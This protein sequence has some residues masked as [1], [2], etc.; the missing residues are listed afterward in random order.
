MTVSILTEI[1]EA[2]HDRLR[3][4]LAATDLDEDEAI[5]AANRA[6]AHDSREERRC[7]PLI[8]SPLYL[9]EIARYPVLTPDEERSLLLALAKGD[10]RAK[11]KLIKHNLRLVVSV[12]K[13]HH[14]YAGTL[15]LIDLIQ[16]GAF[17][18]KTA[19]ERFDLKY[20]KLS[21]YAVQWIRQKITR[22]IQNNGR[23]VRLPV[24]C[25][26]DIRVISKAASEL[27]RQFKR[28]ATFA[29]IAAAID[30]PPAWVTGRLES[31]RPI[32]SL[33]RKLASHGHKGHEPEATLGSLVPVDGGA[34]ET[35]DRP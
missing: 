19:I 15:E 31:I 28:N 29:E 26:A 25:H 5:N 8:H 9:R 35:G 27:S 30:K 1:D 23:T 2:L 32:D 10:D 24:H 7:H 3:T 13:K 17:G 33:D 14:R 20:G 4:A 16:E 22:A 11:E 34:V 18:L 21:T 6:L 12:A